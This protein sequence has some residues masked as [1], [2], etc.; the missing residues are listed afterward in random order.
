MKNLLKKNMNKYIKKE[1]EKVKDIVKF[2]YNDDDLIINIPKSST[3]LPK[4][5]EYYL[6][7]LNDSLFNSAT[8]EILASNWNNNNMP[9]YKYYKVD[10]TKI[11]GNMIRVNGIAFNYETQQD[12]NSIWTGWLPISEI[13]ILK[14]L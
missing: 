2:N 7:E 5:N 12:I 3:I 8:N 1:L 10:V 14:K 13:V 6:V 11:I 9:K 4:E